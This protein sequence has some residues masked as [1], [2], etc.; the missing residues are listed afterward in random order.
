MASAEHPVLGFDDLDDISLPETIAELAGLSVLLDS[1]RA[2]NQYESILVNRY[3]HSTTRKGSTVPLAWET[4]TPLAETLRPPQF[5]G[6]MGRI[7]VTHMDEPYARLLSAPSSG[8]P[9]GE[10]IKDVLLGL[11]VTAQ[12]L[13]SRRHAGSVEAAVWIYQRNANHRQTGEYTRK[14]KPSKRR[15]EEFEQLL[16]ESISNGLRLTRWALQHPYMGAS[17]TRRES[18][19]SH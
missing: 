18:R 15:N 19:G 8:K 5:H 12:L 2:L 7:I 16:H 11:D 14:I 1:D 17:E 10:Y 3:L 9:P 13:S 4:R 6:R